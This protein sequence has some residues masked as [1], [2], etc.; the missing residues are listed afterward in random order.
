MVNYR[1]I[2]RLQ[3]LNHSQR[4][5]ALAVKS[6]RNTI[7]S[8]L[9]AAAENGIRWPLAND[10]TNADLEAIL[11]PSKYKNVSTYVEPDYAYIHKELAKPG[12]TLTLLWEEYCRN[13][14]ESGRTPYMSTQ[15]G[16][17]YL[18]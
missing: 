13:C 6:S 2:L 1:E 9:Q 11:F 10:I 8:A 7:G 17:K 14:Y 15:F 3:S 4:D 16:D 12:V 5:I 18:C